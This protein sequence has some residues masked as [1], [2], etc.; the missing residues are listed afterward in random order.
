MTH[1]AESCITVATSPVE[2]LPKL[3]RSRKRI[4]Q[5]HVILAIKQQVPM[6]THHRSVGI[7]E[8]GRMPQRISKSGRSPQLWI[9]DEIE[10]W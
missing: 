5:I 3:I 9:L 1:E 4:Y 2:S 8:P 6:R 10:V 7:C